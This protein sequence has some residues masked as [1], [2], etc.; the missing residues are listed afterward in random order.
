MDG[1]AATISDLH[2]GI[3][4]TQKAVFRNEGAPS[5]R[6]AVTAYFGKSDGL[7]CVVIDAQYGPQVT[8]DGVSMVGRVPSQLEEQ[9]LD[10][11]LSRGITP[12]YAPWADLG[13]DD[14][15]LVM[16]DQT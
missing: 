1:F 14:L 9:L 15:G 11:M 5:Y 16:Y 13:A 12:Q 6:T 10:Y 8:M 3:G 4:D 7:F 2:R